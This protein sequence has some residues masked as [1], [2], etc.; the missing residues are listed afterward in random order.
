LL[1]P[2]GDS[3][4]LKT[5][6]R[7][8]AP[9]LGSPL[10]FTSPAPALFERFKVSE[11]APW[12]VVALKD[13]NPHTAAAMYIGGTTLDTNGDLPAWLLANRLPT[14]M[15]LT[16]DTFQSVMNAPHAP[17]VVI[18]AVDATTR[19]KVAERFR[20]MAMKWRVRTGGTGISHGRSVV[21]TWMD[22]ERWESWMKSMYGIRKSRSGEIED[23]GVVIADHK[24][25]KYYDTEQSN[26]PIKLTSPSIFSALEGAADGTLRA[27]N[28]ENIV[29]R[30]ARYLNAKLTSIE[31]NILNHPF[32]ALGL[33]SL[34]LVAM[35]SV[36]RR[37]LG[38]DS[39]YDRDSK[40]GRMD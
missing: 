29:E 38:D 26:T 30:I 8:A 27:K 9:L 25:L 10:I 1:H 15:E 22:A 37:C 23:A 39:A 32:Y 28:S 11:S 18:A 2:A 19:D 20:D 33:L 36:L 17:L 4:L 7:L 35:Y 3:E 6:T 24:V 31:K 34:S 21:F 5:I 40:S 16:Q 12:A 14:F 13:R